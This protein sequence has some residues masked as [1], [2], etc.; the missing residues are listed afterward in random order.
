[1]F[2]IYWAKSRFSAG[3]LRMWVQNRQY[4]GR[5]PCN[6][7][8]MTT[9]N[10]N[11]SSH[12]WMGKLRCHSYNDLRQCVLTQQSRTRAYRQL[13]G[14]NSWPEWLAKYGNCSSC[15]SCSWA[16]HEPLSHKLLS[17]AQNAARLGSWAAPKPSRDSTTSSVMLLI[18]SSISTPMFWP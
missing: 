17:S 13:T 9:L 18:F 7:Y 12:S 14:S 11:Q 6:I 8:C 10:P 4:L 16:A 3:R 15:L 2:T 1:M 5:G